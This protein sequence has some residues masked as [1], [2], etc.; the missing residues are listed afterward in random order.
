MTGDEVRN[1]LAL[2]NQVMNV[3]SIGPTGRP[4]LVAMW[5]GFA[6]ADTL[7]FWT[8]NKSQKIVNLQRDPRL[9]CLVESGDTYAELRG[10]EIEGTATITEAQDDLI[11]VGRSVMAR[12][13]APGT[14]VNSDAL[15]DDVVLRLA[16]KRAVVKI[17]VERFV[18]WDH[19][20][21]G[22]GY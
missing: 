12:Y 16:S 5:Y 2:P 14:V 19:R 18:S 13:P 8:F 21:L 3:A 17:D 22:G 9:T 6:D 20:K 10:V 4:H 11:A 7:A 15:T 1:Y